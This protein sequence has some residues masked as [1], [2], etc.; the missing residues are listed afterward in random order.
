MAK[1]INEE[2]SAKFS[3]SGQSRA[4]LTLAAALVYKTKL[5]WVCVG[6]SRIYIY[7]RGSLYQLNEDHDYQNQLLRDCMRSKITMDEAKSD[8]QK[9]ALTS[10]IGHADMPYVDFNK[11]GFAIQRDDK[12]ILCSDGVFD[13]LNNA[14]I[15]ACLDE[16]PQAAAEKIVKSV[17]GK[18]IKE[19][20]NTSI[21]IIEYM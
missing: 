13:A 20:D 10:Y 19:Q 17:L 2:V 12:I 21:M 16:E 15:I 18:K 3:Q 8:P 14:A 5:Y 11:R 6:D 9:N 1:M 4:G 7:R